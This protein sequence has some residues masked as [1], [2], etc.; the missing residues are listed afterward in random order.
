MEQTGMT[1]DE[2]MR[3]IQVEDALEQGYGPVHM[4]ASYG[5]LKVCK[6][7]LKE[8]KLDVNATARDGSYLFSIFA[9]CM[10]F[11]GSA[12]GGMG[13]LDSWI[14]FLSMGRETLI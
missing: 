13:W 3:R 6:F 8:L 14:K 11:V 7:L 4:A 1:V 2:V 5:N 10:T 9:F 12:P